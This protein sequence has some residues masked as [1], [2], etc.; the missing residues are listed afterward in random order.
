MSVLKAVRGRHPDERGHPRHVG[1]HLR[2]DLLHGGQIPG[3]A[4]A[5]RNV[6]EG[7]SLQ[8]LVGQ[9]GLLVYRRGRRRE[10]RLL[11]L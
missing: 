6:V 4:A 10:E 7:R 3:V 9:V 1:H 2:R 8:Q 11:L 5:S